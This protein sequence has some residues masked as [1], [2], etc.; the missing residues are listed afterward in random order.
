MQK[1]LNKLVHVIEFFF[2]ILGL[3]F[4]SKKRLINII[5][6]NKEVSY[7]LYKN[8]IKNLDNKSKSLV[9]ALLYINT[10][11]FKNAFFINCNKLHIYP[12]NYKLT[13]TEKRYYN[14]LFQLPKKTLLTEVFKYHCGLK[15]V[16]AKNLDTL[17]E[18]SSI[19]AG[20]YWGDSALIFAGIYQSTTFAFEPNAISFLELQDTIANNN[21][22]SL[23]LPIQKGISSKNNT[24]F[25]DYSGAN[26]ASKFIAETDIID[27]TKV[28]K[29]EVVAIDNFVKEK[30]I[31]KL[32][33]IHLDIE[34]F[35]T[36]AILGAKNTIARDKP[37]LL[38][39]IYH[40][41]QDFFKIKP[42]IESWNLGYTFKIRKL[43]R[44]RN[45]I[46]LIAYVP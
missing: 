9:K 43:E 20:A 6:S 7:S 21:L 39:S 13:K 36:D 38:I 44:I 2:N 8:L 30:N 29:L 10:N 41:A 31:A 19:T 15:F 37:I 18:S 22:H 5:F 3:S 11:K 12:K 34:G 24:L 35:E 40:N 28:E 26:I 16:P 32:G 33:A 23:I 14:K 25:F 45:E 42:I 46:M 4:L 1:I 17:K 27:I